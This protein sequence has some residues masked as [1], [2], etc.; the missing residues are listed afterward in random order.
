MRC[1]RI[2]DLADLAD[3]GVVK[4]VLERREIGQGAAPVT[5]HRI[6][7]A[8]EAAELE[9]GHESAQYIHV[10]IGTSGHCSMLW[11]CLFETTD[12]SE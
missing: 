6:V 4:V 10:E 5:M 12:L 9:A 7:R 11:K 8:R 3:A 1:L 2:E